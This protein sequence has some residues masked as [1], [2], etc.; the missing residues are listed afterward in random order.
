MTREQARQLVYSDIDHMRMVTSM[1]A[2]T[3]HQRS[4]TVDKWIATASKKELLA[5]IICLLANNH[6]SRLPKADLVC[7]GE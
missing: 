5:E 7:I 6:N 3:F 4:E 2:E 1:T